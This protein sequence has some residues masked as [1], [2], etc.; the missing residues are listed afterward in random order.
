MQSRIFCLYWNF[1]GWEN[2][3]L[4]INIDVKAWGIT[5]HLPG[6]YLAMGFRFRKALSVIKEQDPKSLKG[7]HEFNE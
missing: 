7:W 4:G 3:S 1:V 2:I 6:G 5:I